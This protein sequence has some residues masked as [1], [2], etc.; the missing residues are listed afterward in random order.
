MEGYEQTPP[1][2]LWEAVEAGIP[3][4]KAT[5]PWIWALAGV[6]AVVLAAVLLWNPASTPVGPAIAE[7]EKL[8]VVE[9]ELIDPA[10]VDSEPIAV[11]PGPLSVISD[12]DRE[13]PST[14]S[15]IAPTTPDAPVI[16]DSV[17]VIPVS[18]RESESSP[19]DVTPVAPATPVIPDSDRESESSIPLTTTVR[20]RSNPRLTASLLASGIPGSTSSTQSG[21]GLQQSSIRSTRMAPAALLSRNKPSETQ[22]RH[23]VALRVGAMFNL[24]FTEHWGLE[25]GLQLTNLQ[26]QTKSVSGSITAVKDKTVSYLGVPLLAVYTPLR[27]DR[28][29]LYTSAGPMFEYGFRSFGKDETYMGGERTDQ[30]PFSEK[31]SDFAFS[32]G[33]NLGVQWMVSSAGAIFVQ[34]GLSWHMAGSGNMETFYTEHPLAFG[35]TA[36]FRFG[37]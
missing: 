29:S 13:S 14:P 26:T 35:V 6:A 17:A 27:L 2:G 23:S 12:T 11:I 18:D 8:E 32:L 3:V 21:Y 37:F 24:S 20:T 28:F 15:Y 5:F 19:S 4:R 1:E 30:S 31:E 10:P 9:P 34:P 25:T 22:T 33:L 16:P 7:A 36:G